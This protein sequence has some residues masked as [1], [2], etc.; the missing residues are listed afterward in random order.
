MHGYRLAIAPGAR[1]ARTAWRRAR[2]RDRAPRNASSCPRLPVVRL[3]RPSSPSR[4]SQPARHPQQELAAGSP[5]SVAAA[6]GAARPRLL[7]AVAQGPRHHSRSGRAVRPPPPLPSRERPAD[8]ASAANGRVPLDPLRGS[9]VAAS[10]REPLPQDRPDPGARAHPVPPAATRAN[11]GRLAAGSRAVTGGP[12]MLSAI[13]AR[14]RPQAAAPARTARP[15]VRRRSGRDRAGDAGCGPGAGPASAA[16]RRTQDGQC[17]GCSDSI[18]RFP[19][20][21]PSIG[22]Q[23]AQQMSLRGIRRM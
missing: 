14:A 21:G 20:A 13:A 16:G 7:R 11:A 4:T 12:R 5:R 8:R 1:G 22:R 15:G 6:P 10:S 23:Q 18:G 3:A 2:T 17:N 9:A 19:D